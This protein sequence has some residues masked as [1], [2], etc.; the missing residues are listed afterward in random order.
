[1]MIIIRIISPTIPILVPMIK[2]REVVFELKGV[3][4]EPKGVVFDELIYHKQELLIQI[5]P[6]LH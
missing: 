1:M 5:F 2:P 6:L 3:A 4:F